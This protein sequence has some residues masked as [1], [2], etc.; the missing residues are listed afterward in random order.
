MK[1]RGGIY[2]DFGL[3][4]RIFDLPQDA[5]LKNIEVNNEIEEIKVTFYTNEEG[6][7]E[8][9]PGAKILCKKIKK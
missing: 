2:F 8:Y 6:Y 7:G 9:A 5:L 4:K 3:I 1:N